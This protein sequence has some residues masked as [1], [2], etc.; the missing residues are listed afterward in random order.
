MVFRNFKVRDNA[1]LDALK[2]MP[3][4]NFHSICSHYAVV[5][6]PG[7]RRKPFNGEPCKDI[8]MPASNFDGLGVTWGFVANI[9]PLV[10]RRKTFKRERV[11]EVT[12]TWNGTSISFQGNNRIQRLR[13][14]ISSAPL[15]L[16]HGL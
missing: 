16:V 2:E 4:L 7:E 1:F 13:A 6:K 12:N 9:D 14:L 3:V 5:P 8:D 10:Q 15:K 11:D